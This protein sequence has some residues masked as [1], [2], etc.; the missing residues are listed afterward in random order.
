MTGFGHPVRASGNLAIAQTHCKPEG[1]DDGN[2]IFHLDKSEIQ[3][4]FPDE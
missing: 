4:S 3:V 2:R 1:A